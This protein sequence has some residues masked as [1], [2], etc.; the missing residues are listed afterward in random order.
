MAKIGVVGFGR[1]GKAVLDFLIKHNPD[2]E[3]MLYD[4]TFIGDMDVVEKYES[5]GVRFV[6]GENRFYELLKVEMIILS[7]GVN[8]RTVRF[9]R[10][11]D[12]KIK[13]VS[14]LEYA[15][16]FIQ[17]QIVAV[18]GTNGKSTTVSLIHHILKTNGISSF[19][20]GNIGL[21]LISVVDEAKSDSVVVVEVSSFQLEEIKKFR[22]DIG[23]LLNV[24]PDHLDR[25]PSFDSYFQAKMNI[26]KN[27]TV[28]DYGIINFDDPALRNQVDRHGFAKEIGFSTSAH[29]KLGAHC[30]VK[31]LYLNIGA[32]EQKIPLKKIKLKG[33]HNL[34]NVMASVL[35]THLL[36]LSARAIEKGLSGFRGLPHR[37]ESV[38][39]IGD[40]AFFND[41]KAT[42]VD[43]ALKSIDSIDQPLVVILGGRDKGSDFTPLLKSLKKRAKKV[44]VIGEA[45]PAILKQLNDIQTKLEEVK[46]FSSALDRG[47]RLLKKTGGVVLLAPACASFDMFG[48]F[49]ERGLAFRKEFGKLKKK[50]KNG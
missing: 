41:S 50:V 3:I 44:L 8:G 32:G 27:Q 35:V 26:F 11:R 47:H 31:N 2:D 29:L 5:H 16:R 23:V 24:T 4:D 22:P 39:S 14:E 34:E 21:P 46:N 42:N 10:L 49:E 36:G 20:T 45:A 9:G 25:Y 37:M 6:M 13:I 48:N 38:G 15:S 17:S 1:T 7:P 30:D 28:G 19:L 33:I 40:V 18:T 12:Q 43:A